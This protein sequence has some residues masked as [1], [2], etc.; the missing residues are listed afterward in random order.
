M[1]GGVFYGFYL[2]YIGGVE[3][4]D[5][6]RVTRT[7]TPWGSRKFGVADEYAW[8]PYVRVIHK[9]YAGGKPYAIA[10]ALVLMEFRGAAWSP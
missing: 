3:F 7:N 4:K 10:Q 2:H 6:L 5:T 1:G 8:A 9:V